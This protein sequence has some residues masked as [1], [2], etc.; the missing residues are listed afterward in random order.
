MDLVQWA[1]ALHGGS[2]FTTAGALVRTSSTTAPLRYEASP[3]DRLELRG[4]GGVE[5]AVTCST[6][7]GARD[8]SASTFLSGAHLVDCAFRAPGTIDA[9]VQS[10]RDANGSCRALRGT[11][12]TGEGPLAVDLA[13]G[14]AVTQV[15]NDSGLQRRTQ[16]ERAGTIG[17]PAGD[18]AFAV[19]EQ[20]NTLELVGTGSAWDS[21]EAFADAVHTSLASW[22]LRDAV[23]HWQ[24]GGGP[25]GRLLSATGAIS[26][27][28]VTRGTVFADGGTVWLQVGTE[29]V[30]F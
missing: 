16:R 28:G 2:G 21:E 18:V 14:T 24:S 19:D 13:E 22:S 12:V 3:P 23:V 7:E 29:Q 10:E 5:L 9:G 17:L 20:R 4:V 8:V 11:L 30:P 6:F 26:R 25:G 27:D 15:V 1:T